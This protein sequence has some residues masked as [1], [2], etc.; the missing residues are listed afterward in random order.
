MSHSN[1]A[2]INRAFW[3]HRAEQHYDSEFYDNASFIKGRDSL[4]NIED[5]F[6]AKDLSGLRVLHLMCHFG[7][8]TLSMARR[9]AQVTGI[10]LSDTAVERANQLKMDIGQS[11][12]RFIRCNVLEA[13]QYLN[14]E[15][16]DLIFSSFGTIGWLPELTKWGQIIAQHLKPGGRFVFA[17]FHPVVWMFDDDFTNFQYPYFNVEGYE[18]E[19][20]GSY[21][22]PEDEKKHNSVY[23]NHSIADTLQA[24]LEA[25]LTIKQFK[26]YD[27][28]PHNC[29]AKTIAGANG[30]QIQGLAGKLPMV[31]AL[32]AV[33]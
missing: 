3:N 10:D 26:E 7:Q 16:F 22:A 18:E 32:E 15:Q 14:G 29:F 2:S 24:L 20:Q 30:W 31:F 9:G 23:F 4:T 25:G 17:E 21:A 33:R 1:Y 6:L 5:E 8:D 28:S 12:A 19:S 11:D 13:D 27:F